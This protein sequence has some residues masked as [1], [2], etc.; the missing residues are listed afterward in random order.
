MSNFAILIVNKENNNL[1]GRVSSEKFS[2]SREVENFLRK[3]YKKSTTFEGLVYRK[4]AFLPEDNSNLYVGS[5]TENEY[6]IYNSDEL[7][8]YAMYK[9]LDREEEKI[10]IVRGS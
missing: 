9:D 10:E 2:S 6:F 7:I 4:G 5:D 8:V 1:V 3:K